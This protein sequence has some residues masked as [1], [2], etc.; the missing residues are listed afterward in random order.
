MKKGE[1]ETAKASVE[2]YKT[3]LNDLKN[4]REYDTLS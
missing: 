2:R 4:N 1:I 3:Q